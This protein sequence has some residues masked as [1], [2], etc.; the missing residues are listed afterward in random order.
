V[1]LGGV[2]VM[3]M[4][5][6]SQE[7]SSS[8]LPEPNTIS[9][10]LASPKTAGWRSLVIRVVE[11]TLTFIS[12]TRFVSVSVMVALS[13]LAILPLKPGALALLGAVGAVLV[14]GEELVCAWAG[15]EAKATAVKR[16]S[17]SF[18]I[19]FIVFMVELL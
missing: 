13:T 4:A 3:R 19:D 15:N 17:E 18:V 2:V 8:F 12:P 9:P 11:V 7:P 5:L 6:A 14:V 16:T 10:S 1:R